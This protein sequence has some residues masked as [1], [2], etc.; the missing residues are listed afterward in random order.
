MD[1]ILFAFFALAIFRVE[2][3]AEEWR[4]I[5]PLRSTRADVER[6]LGKPNESGR[7]EVNGDR[8]DINYSDGPCR[9]LYNS[10]AKGNCKCLVLKDT[11]LSIYVEP[12]HL[13]FSKLKIDKSKFTRTGIAVGNSM[14]SYS[15][16]IGRAHV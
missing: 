3:F 5:V 13:K 8:A 4:G 15:N 11:V 14:F 10:L 7:Y 6:L 1:K 2:V 12:E 16:E 9:G